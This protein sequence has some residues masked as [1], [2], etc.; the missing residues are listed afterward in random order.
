[1]VVYGVLGVCMKA[2]TFFASLAAILTTVKLTFDVVEKFQ[3]HGK[4]LHNWFI[5]Q[6]VRRKLATVSIFISTRVN[7]VYSRENFTFLNLNSITDSDSP[8]LLLRSPRVGVIK[9]IS[10]QLV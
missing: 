4:A 9:K 1:M 10:F 5:K 8:R 7:H 3:I 2:L 6:S